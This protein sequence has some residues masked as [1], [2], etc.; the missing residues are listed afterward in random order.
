MP[1]VD[2]THIPVHNGEQIEK[3]G[4]HKQGIWGRHDT[5]TDGGW[6]AFTTDPTRKD[7]AWVVR[8]HP[9]HGRSVVLYRDTDASPHTE[10]LRRQMHGH[11][12]F[13]L[14]RHRILL[15]VTQPSVTTDY[16]TEP[17]FRQSLV[18]E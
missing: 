16:G 12:G 6:V 11:A 13:D 15:A 3:I 17:T 8:H 2:D 14:L 9:E 1:F 5:C 18:T 10:R 4:R 7:L